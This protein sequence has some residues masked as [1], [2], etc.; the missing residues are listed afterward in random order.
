V[1]IQHLI[2]LLVA[3]IGSHMNLT[4]KFNDKPQ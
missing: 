3:N 2:D 1:F 4:W